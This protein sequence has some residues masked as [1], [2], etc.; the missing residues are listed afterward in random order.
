MSIDSFGIVIGPRKSNDRCSTKLCPFFRSY[1]AQSA[2]GSSSS[3]R[4]NFCPGS[5]SCQCHSHSRSRSHS[6]PCFFHKRS[7][8]AAPPSEPAA[9]HAAKPSPSTISTKYQSIE[10]SKPSAAW[11]QCW[12]PRICSASC[13]CSTTFCATFPHEGASSCCITHG[14]LHLLLCSRRYTR[15]AEEV[16]YH[17][18]RCQGHCLA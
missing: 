16:R 9:E 15:E 5:C 18:R 13:L 8:I 17:P 1:K 7:S 3:C 14:I 4:F 11:R 12:I 6:R 10:P 2:K